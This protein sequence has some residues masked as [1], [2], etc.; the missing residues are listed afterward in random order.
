[1]ANSI[2]PLSQIPPPPAAAMKQPLP[3]RRQ[4]HRKHPGADAS[5]RCF[6]SARRRITMATPAPDSS[7]TEDIELEHRSTARKAASAIALPRRRGAPRP[8]TQKGYPSRHHDI[9]GWLEDGSPWDSHPASTVV[10]VAIHAPRK[11]ADIHRLRPQ[12]IGWLLQ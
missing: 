1:M 12:S 3:R 10:G 6:V 7:Q 9:G 5:A 4:R 2:P 8:I 11:M